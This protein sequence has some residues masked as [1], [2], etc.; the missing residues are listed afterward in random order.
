MAASNRPVAITVICI[1]GFIGALLSAPMLVA[2]LGGANLGGVALPGWYGPYLG[3]SIIIGVISLIGL[4]M[5]K[6]WGAILYAVLF[7]VNQ[8]VLFS[9]GMWSPFALL[10]P[11]I[12]LAVAFSQFSK[13]D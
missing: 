10:I 8:I 6:K 2:I 1:I 12:I 7:L 5:M 3:L 11:L 4:W 13:M 9:A